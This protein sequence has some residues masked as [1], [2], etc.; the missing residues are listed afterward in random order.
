MFILGKVLVAEVSS[1]NIFLTTY[2]CFLC[3]MRGDYCTDTA[4]SL[5]DPEKPLLG[6]FR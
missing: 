1:T 4:P 2:V 3:G 6:G 5:I